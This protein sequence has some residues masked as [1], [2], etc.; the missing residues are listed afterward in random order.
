MSPRVVARQQKRN[1]TLLANTAYNTI[2]NSAVYPTTNK[3]DKH[4][5]K[6]GVSSNTPAQPPA[7]WSLGTVRKPKNF[8]ITPPKKSAFT[9]ETPPDQIKLH[10]LA[11]FVGKRGGGKSVAV[12]NLL[13]HMK[14]TDKVLD[15]V[16]LISPTYHSNKEIWAPLNIDI[17]KD[18]FE[19]PDKQALDS[20]MAEIDQEREDYIRFMSEKILYEKL[21]RD[22]NDPN[23]SV[24]QI[25]DEV[26]L[27]ADE[28]NWYHNPPKWKYANGDKPARMALIVD[29]SLGTK[30]FGPKSGFTNLCV[31]HRHVG[32]GIGVS[33]FILAQTY[34][35]TNGIPRAIRENCTHLALFK[36]KDQNQIA[37]ICEEIGSDIDVED[38]LKLFQYATSEPFGFLFVDFSPKTPQQAFRKN[39]AQY[40]LASPHHFV[41]NKQ[42]TAAEVGRTEALPL[43]IKK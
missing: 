34:S 36:N 18:L 10:S 6:S 35:T 40:L 13:Q 37:K 20:L 12:S 2:K 33:I 43:D 8:I 27:F 23:K 38:F 28:K 14:Y 26:L 22:L 32:E 24:D 3:N 41:Q 30:L 29:D 25:E 39:F 11:V 17:N 7:G 9:I 21:H 1:N 15:R 19:Q 4:N 31:K 16:F 42:S 5:N